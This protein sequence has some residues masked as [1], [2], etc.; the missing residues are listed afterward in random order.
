MGALPQHHRHAD[1]LAALH[2]AVF[3]TDGSTDRATRAAAAAGT[4]LPPL[5]APY[6]AAVRDAS[7][8]ITDA[9]VAALKD[10]GWT[11]EQLFEVTIAAALGRAQR[12]LDAGLRAL[13]AES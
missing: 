2:R 1:K 7:Y 11:E 4:D 6:L 13:G 9:D 8:R 10:A 3:E 5:L 12:S